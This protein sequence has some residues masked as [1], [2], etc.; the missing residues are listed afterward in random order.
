ML[1]GHFDTQSGTAWLHELNWSCFSLSSMARDVQCWGGGEKL[2]WF[3]RMGFLTKLVSALKRRNLVLSQ[4]WSFPQR[5]RNSRGL[6]I[7]CNFKPFINYH[8][9]YL[10]NRLYPSFPCPFRTSSQSWKDRTSSKYDTNAVCL[11][12]LKEHFY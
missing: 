5:S 9:N 7:L 8:L 6:L 3:D 2:S 4:M 1:A 10:S 11:Q 12:F